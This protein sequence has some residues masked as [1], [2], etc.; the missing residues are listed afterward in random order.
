MNRKNSRDVQI[1]IL[2]S[3]GLILIILAHVSPP[4]FI[5][6]V[7]TFDVPLMIFVSA[8]SFR[9][10]NKESIPY[11]QYVISR[12]RRMLAPVWIFLSIFFLIIYFFNIQ[13]FNSFLTTKTIISSCLLIGGIGYVW[14]IQVFLLIAILS[15]VYVKL[16]KRASPVTLI[17][18]SVCIVVFSSVLKGPVEQI[19]SSV[20]KRVGTD[21]IMPMLTYGMI[22]IIGF[23]FN[24]FS[25]FNKITLVISHL[26]LLVIYQ[27]IAFLNKNIFVLPQD[28][29][30][31]PGIAYISWAFIAITLLYYLWENH[32]ADYNNIIQKLI[33]FIS[34]NSMWLYLLHIPVVEYLN[35]TN[36]ITNFFLRW[37]IAITIPLVLFFIQRWIIQQVT[38]RIKNPRVSRYIWQAFTG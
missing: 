36:I 13:V 20:I 28:D 32:K 9:I 15:P 10:T 34:S 25:L 37:I 31:P 21:I 35:R 4:S 29:K 11:T 33:V 8:L 22:F 38:A 24:C 26:I 3:I 7:R 12:L 14:I 16:S 2:R 19:T 27:S 6:Q 23:N 1:D 17:I 18:A 30:Y 5:F